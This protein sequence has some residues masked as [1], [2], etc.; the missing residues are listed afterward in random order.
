MSRRVSD[1]MADDLVD[2]IVPPDIF[3]EPALTMGVKKGSRMNATGFHESILK[4]MHGIEQGTDGWCIHTLFGK[5]RWELLLNRL[6]RR[7]TTQTT[8]SMTDASS[9][10]DLILPGAGPAEEKH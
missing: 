10:I 3:L 2:R 6:H 1:A 8:P 7:F 5:N 4:R 9:S